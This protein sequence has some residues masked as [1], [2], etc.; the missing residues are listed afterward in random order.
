M[1]AQKRKLKSADDKGKLPDFVIGEIVERKPAANTMETDDISKEQQTEAFPK[2]KIFD[3]SSVKVERGKSLFAQIMESENAEKEHNSDDDQMDIDDHGE[4]SSNFVDIDNENTKILQ[5]MSEQEILEEQQ[6]LMNSIDPKILAFVKSRHKTKYQKKVEFTPEPIKLTTL[7]SEDFPVLDILKNESSKNWLHFD[8]LEPEKLEWTRDIEKTFENLKPGQTYEARFDWKGFLLPFI[9]SD[10]SKTCDDRHLHLHG[11]EAHRPG[12]TLQELLRLARATVLQQRVAALNAI[13]GIINIYNQG[14]YDGILELPMS[15]IFFFLRFAMDENTT[16]IIEASS[17]ALAYL[18]YNDTDE[19]LLDIAYETRTG[20]VQ[21]L[22]DNRRAT[23]AGSA[24][25]EEDVDLESSLKQLSFEENRKKLFESNVE[26]LVDDQDDEKESYNDFHLAEVNLIECLV[27]TD[28]IER[29]TYILTVTAIDDV[30]LVSCIKILIR[31]ARSKRNF[32]MKILE[33]KNLIDNLIQKHLTKIDEHKEPHFIVVKLFRVISSYDRT[34]AAELSRLGLI[35]RLKSYAQTIGNMN[36]NVLKLQIECFRFL[37]LFTLQTHDETVFTEIASALRYLLEWHYQFLDFQLDN[38]FIIRQ[39]ASAL[40]H[41][42]GTGNVVVMFPMFS[43]VFK[44][45]SSKWFMMAAR[46]GVEEFSQKII[47]SSCLDVSEKF[48]SFSSEYFYDFVDDYLLRFMRSSTFD[49]MSC[50]LCES[51]PLFKDG[52]DR[53]N[54]YRPL[55]NLGSIV[56]T[57]KKSPPTL[58]FTQEYSVF[59]MKSMLMFIKAFDNMSNVNNQDYHRKLSELFFSEHIEK[60]LEGFSIQ[61]NHNLSA[62][63]F[64]KKEIEFIYELLNSRSLQFSPFLLKV[65][66]NLLNCFTQENLEKILYIFENFVFNGKFYYA[67]VK[68]EELN[69]WKFIYNGVVMSKLSAMEVR[70]LE[71]IIKFL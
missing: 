21:P 2:P 4:R 71:S 34:F 9:D 14:Y 41:L 12:Y 24:Q 63:W 51:T 61:F 17:R 18:F 5:S 53:C 30:T 23:I 44:M 59:V 69:K 58:V 16:A 10:E 6:K 1:F 60:Y 22:L 39:H 33:K 48:A 20:V 31:I 54:I 32:A 57:H 11:E 15:K 37:R 65:A 25:E 49:K 40:L 7:K 36:V 42:L 70:Y 64:L 67:S 68:L 47:L 3:Y 29:I 13:A 26:D 28:I 19:T 66:F 62:N 50:N 27:R 38:H 45:C 8:V 56:R 55:I 43:E 35:D 52:S 46:H